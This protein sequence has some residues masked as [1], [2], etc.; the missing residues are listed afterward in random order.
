MP[1]GVWIIDVAMKISAIYAQS[2]L[3]ILKNLIK[4]VQIIQNIYL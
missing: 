4:K 2:A 3:F 1:I